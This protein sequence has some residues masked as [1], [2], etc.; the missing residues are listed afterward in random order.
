VLWVLLAA[1]PAVFIVFATALAPGS[2]VRL[3]LVENGRQVSKVVDLAFGAG[4]HPAFMAPMA[5]ASLAT[6]AGM[7]IILDSRAA[8]QRLVL[9]GERLGPLLAGRLTLVAVAALL[10]TGVSLAVTA[11]V[12]SIG[13]WGGYIAASVILALT[14]ATIGVILAPLFGRVAGVLIAFVVPFLDLGIAQD[15]MLHPAP[16]TWAHFLPGYGGSRVLTSAVLTHSFSQ[17]GPMLTALAWLAG[18]TVAA[19]LLFSHSMHT[20]RGAR[21]HAPGRGAPP[22][23][24]R[25]AT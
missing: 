17:I 3:T 7:F 18:A 5:I 1:V 20:A 6:L 8:D 25:K 13:Q 19:A 24:Q 14:Y 4:I 21:P 10:A 15:P 16:P 9:A 22:H 23:A 12:A 11:T 2:Q